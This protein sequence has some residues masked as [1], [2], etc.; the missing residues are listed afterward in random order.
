MLLLN[1]AMS[2]TTG[3]R[4]DYPA[5]LQIQG[6]THA[7]VEF[8]SEPSEQNFGKKKNRDDEEIDD[9]RI[10]ATVKYLGGDARTKKGKEDSLP[11]VKGNEY[12]LWIA[13]TLRGKFLDI[14]NYKDGAVAPKL[15]GTKWKIWR[16]EVGT[17]GHRVYEAELQPATL[18]PTDVKTPDDSAI[19]LQLKK[20]LEAVGAIDKETWYKFCKEKGAADGE[21]ITAKMAELGYAKIESTKILPVK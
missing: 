17:G 15:V 9:I 7:F 20:S 2:W 16:G 18:S 13:A 3:A 12:T 14:L 4:R 21:A 19:L 1:I 10:K 11:A 8:V 6:D 5:S